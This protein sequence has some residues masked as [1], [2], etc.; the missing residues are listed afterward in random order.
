MKCSEIL[1][2][3]HTIIR[4]GL[5]IVDGML[6][7][8]QDGQRI[9]ICDAASILKFL[10]IFTDQY[11][12]AMEE[13]VLFPALLGATPSNGMLLQLASEHSGE[14]ALVAEIEDS[15]MSR[16]GMAF[17]R[18]AHELTSLLR[19]H[20]ETEETLV[21]DLAEKH[22]SKEQDDEIV[23]Q[24]LSS[25]TQVEGFAKFSILE[26]RYTRKP[27]TDVVKHDYSRPRPQGVASSL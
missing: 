23:A 20:C 4:R 6:K 3:D 22:L 26:R 18:G 21:C 15:L 9:E 8:L 2:Q 5:D 13:R 14:R 16:R 24:F 12:Q 19:T 7:K 17:F 27:S 11:H 25:R 1:V 10:R